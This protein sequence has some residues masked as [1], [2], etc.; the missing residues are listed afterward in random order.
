MYEIASTHRESAEEP[1]DSPWSW[2]AT[3]QWVTFFALQAVGEVLPAYLMRTHLQ[4][5]PSL[6]AQQQ[7]E[8]TKLTYQKHGSQVQCLLESCM[9]LEGG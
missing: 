7:P 3:G 8:N 4:I 5:A 1:D 6:K 9:I 2:T